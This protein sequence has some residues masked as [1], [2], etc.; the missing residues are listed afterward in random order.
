MLSW[1]DFRY[2]KAIAPKK[3]DELDDTPSSWD[4][5]EGKEEPLDVSEEDID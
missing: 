4:E 1:D 2:I 5:F 3:R